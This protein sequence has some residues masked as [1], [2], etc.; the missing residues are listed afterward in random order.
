MAGAAAYLEQ[1]IDRYSPEVAAIA[2]AALKKLRKQFLGANLLVYERRN[3]LPIG[4]APAGRAA[5]VSIVLYQRWVRFFFLEGIALDD[6]EHRLEGT[7]NQV[8]SIKLDAN[9]AILDDPYIRN[10]I[11][12]AVR[13]AA[14]DLTAGQGSIVLKSQI[15]S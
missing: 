13:L 5:I 10:L 3:Q 14:A 2:R 1:A 8:R 4:L 7:G 9:A 6:P 15:S 12:H 11:T